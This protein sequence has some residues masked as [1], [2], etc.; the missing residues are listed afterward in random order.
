VGTSVPTT[1]ARRASTSERVAGEL[2]RAIRQGELL[3]GEHV[4]QE[5]WADRLGVSR[6]PIREALKIL[7][8]EQLVFY[9]THRGYFVTKIAASEMVQ[10]Y[11]MRML[12]EPEVLRSVGWPA[13]DELARLVTQVDRA[14]EAMA[15]HDIQEAM[16]IDRDFYFFIYDL[17]PL[18]YIVA[19]VKRL[20]S[21]SDGYRS[22]SM[23]GDLRTDPS[24][25]AFHRRHH[26]MV[27]ALRRHDHKS[28]VSIV[29]GERQELLE[30]LGDA[31]PVFSGPGEALADG[32]HLTAP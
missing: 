29:L 26:E 2:R 16:E 28:L 12:L 20:W 4:R 13:E 6:V 11:R 23:L 30:R 18:R 22:A 1:V 5:E 19:E 32:E 15:R 10:I 17:S 31:T 27:R 25:S 21:M 3:P 9:D 8:S 7:A 14:A 24:A